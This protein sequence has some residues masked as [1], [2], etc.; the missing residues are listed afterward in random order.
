M[1]RAYAYCF[2][3]AIR[4]SDSPARQSAGRGSVH[5][6]RPYW[7]QRQ[8]QPGKS[9]QARRDVLLLGEVRVQRRVV[10][11]REAP[12]VQVAVL[13]VGHVGHRVAAGV[14]DELGRHDDDRAQPVRGRVDTAEVGEEFREARVVAED[15]LAA[16]VHPDDV[17]RPLEGAPHQGDPAVLAQMRDRLRGAPGEVQVGHGQFVENGEGAAEPFGGEVD[18]AVPGQGRGRGEEEGLCLDE[19]AE[20]AVDALIGLSHV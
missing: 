2:S 7:G 8:R 19:G 11:A 12:A 6:L 4:R 15:R 13:V 17:G 9:V 14:A 18:R 16:A 3:W 20:A 5:R 10:L 1:T